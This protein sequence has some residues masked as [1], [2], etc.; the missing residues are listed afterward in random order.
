ME[1][2]YGSCHDVSSEFEADSS[3]HDKRSYSA[4]ITSSESRRLQY[5]AMP[6]ANTD[7]VSVKW[8]KKVGRK[9]VI[10]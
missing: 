1:K 3:S 9:Y 6:S 5:L 10:Q 7:E 4:V 2:D 8:V